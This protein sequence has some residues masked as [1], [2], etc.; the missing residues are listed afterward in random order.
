MDK[1]QNK[2]NSDKLPTEKVAKND[3]KDLKTKQNETFISFK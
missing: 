3:L 2:P 1:L